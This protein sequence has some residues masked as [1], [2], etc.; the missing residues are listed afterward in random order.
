MVEVYAEYLVFVDPCFILDLKN[1]ACYSLK[2]SPKRIL[3]F[4]LEGNRTALSLLNRSKNKPIFLRNLKR[5][6]VHRQMSLFEMSKLF[7]RINSVYK[8]ASIERQSI[9]KKTAQNR[10]MESQILSDNPGMERLIALQQKINRLRPITNLNATGLNQLLTE[11]APSSRV[12]SGEAIIFQN[13]VVEI[14][15]ELINRSDRP[16][17]VMTAPPAEPLPSRYVL[18]LILEFVRALFENSIP[19]Q[20]SQ[21][22]II[23]KYIIKC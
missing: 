18:A 7:M 15:K 19:Q 4:A 12:L 17:E 6:L 11:F 10:K 1:F 16:L 5:L 22:Q 14:F 9:R 3:K 23:I 20:N 8:Q 21:Q 2:V 13:E